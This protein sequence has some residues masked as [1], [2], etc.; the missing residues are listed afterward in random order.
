[1]DK[2]TET[3]S[4]QKA[5]KL[6]RAMKTPNAKIDETI[7]ELPKSSQDLGTIEE[8]VQQEYLTSAPRGPMDGKI[9]IDED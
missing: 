7:E 1:M 3:Q 8:V 9:S 6:L 2:H 5:N 4:L